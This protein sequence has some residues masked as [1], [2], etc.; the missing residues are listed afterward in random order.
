[1]ETNSRS[2]LRVWSPHKGRVRLKRKNKDFHY[3]D[4]EKQQVTFVNNRGKL[5]K[6]DAHVFYK[7]GVGKVDRGVVRDLADRLETGHEKK[8]VI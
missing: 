6:L 2:S 3:A 5:A 7:G 4:E 8:P 1:V